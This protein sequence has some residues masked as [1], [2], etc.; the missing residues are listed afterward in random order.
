[1]S[2]QPTLA[3]PVADPTRIPLYTWRPPPGQATVRSAYRC[4]R[5]A[6]S[7]A[8]ITGGGR[9]IGRR[10]ARAFAAAGA[11]VALL[12]RSRDEL[13]ATA[14]LIDA[15]GSRGKIASAVA[16]VT[17]RDA[18]AEAVRELRQAVGPIDLLVNN[19]GISGPMGPL[20]LVDE[21]EWWQ[22]MDVNVRGLVTATRLVLPDMV[23]RRRGRILNIS[24]QAGVHRW[25]LV[26]GYSV[27]KAAVTK[28]S[29]NLAHE[30]AAYGIAVLS[31]HPGLLPIGMSEQGA[32]ALAS[33]NEYAVRVWRWVEREL[34]EGRGADPDD[35]IDL[36]VRLADGD[37][38]AL[39]GRHLS[40]HDDLDELVARADD[41][42]RRDLL[43]LHPT[44]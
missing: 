19:A 41:I 20:W 18:M 15:D 6:G 8:L 11:D 7:H 9:G 31:V 16:D 5:L 27:S 34:A 17:D 12:A 10:L 42:R 4:H 29:E 36:L 13:D 37:G 21:D 43:V 44:R 26:S 14:E 35:A 2:S 40:V 32:D 3:R 38:D 23:A 22:A 39:S 33:G 1:M 25:P 24:S 28:L 30:T